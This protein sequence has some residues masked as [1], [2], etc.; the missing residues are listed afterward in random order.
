MLVGIWYQVDSN[1]RKINISCEKIITEDIY[2]FK[3]HLGYTQ[4]DVETSWNVLNW[5][6]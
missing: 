4:K 2:C 1:P 5:G 6:E 3:Y